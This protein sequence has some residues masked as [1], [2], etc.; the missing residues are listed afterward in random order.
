MEKIQT[1]ALSG[2]EGQPF[3]GPKIELAARVGHLITRHLGLCQLV[4]FVPT[5]KSKSSTYLLRFGR[6]KH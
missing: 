6:P 3:T 1:L 5:L 2:F 4:S